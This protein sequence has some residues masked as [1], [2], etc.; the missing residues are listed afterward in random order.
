MMRPPLLIAKLKAKKAPKKNLPC[1]HFNKKKYFSYCINNKDQN[2]A[3][4]E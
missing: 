1:S 4:L 2:H 3:Y